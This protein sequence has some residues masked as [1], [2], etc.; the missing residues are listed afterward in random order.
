MQALE[1]RGIFYFIWKS[2][3]GMFTRLQVLQ[4]EYM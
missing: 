2:K 3:L 1:L 4:G